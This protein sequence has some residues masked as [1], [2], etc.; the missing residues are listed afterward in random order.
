EVLLDIAQRGAGE[1]PGADDAA[2]ISLHEGNAR[3]FHGHVGTRT[4]GDAH[5]RGG[6]S[7]RSP[8]SMTMRKPSWRR[9]CKASAVVGLTRSVNRNI[10]AA[11][12][13]TA[14]NTGVT[15]A[16][17]SACTEAVRES[18]TLM[19]CAFRNVAVPARTF[20]PRI[21]PS[22][23]PPAAARK[24]VAGARGSF[25]S[26]AA[27]TMARAKGCSL[28]RSTLAASESKAFSGSAMPSNIWTLAR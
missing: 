3:A 18:G 27:R 5:V 17:P 26:S 11:L 20:L 16:D 1:A 15:A 21:M 9:N 7:W 8:V 23:P 22:T 25:F 28:A 6:E 24:S 4:H 13:F 12:P 14:T 19:P 2:Q 10:P